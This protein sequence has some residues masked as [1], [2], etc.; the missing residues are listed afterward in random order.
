MTD[1]E[2]RTVTLDPQNDKYLDEHDNASAFVNRMIEHARK[3]G[4]VATAG[5]DVQIRQKQR[6]LETAEQKVANLERDIAEL[7][8]LREQLM[9]EDQ[10]EIEKARAALEGTERDPANPAIK[11]WAD[12]LGIT[13]EELIRELAEDENDAV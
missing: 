3:T 12:K 7:Q 6:E 2:R 1:K 11:N 8:E 9:A 10:A 13:A 5:I 4:E